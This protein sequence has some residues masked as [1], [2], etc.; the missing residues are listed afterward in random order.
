MDA[1]LFYTAEKGSRA[2]TRTAYTQNTPL[3]Q[4]QPLPPLLLQPLLL[5]AMLLAANPVQQQL[6]GQQGLQHLMQ[7]LLPP[8]RAT[9]SPTFVFRNHYA[10]SRSCSC[11]CAAVALWGIY[12][13]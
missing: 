1:Q 2:G 12:G 4:K 9:S 10:S 6:I 5:L 3:Q 7:Q 11:R 8:C 13:D